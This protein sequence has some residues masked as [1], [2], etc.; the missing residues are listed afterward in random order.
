MKIAVCGKGGSGKSTITSLLAKEFAS[1]GR[2][3]LVIDCDESNYGLH[4]QLGM[5]IPTSLTE[6]MGGKRHV[7][8]GLSNGPQN[9]PMLFEHRWSIDELPKECCSEKDGIKLLTPGKIETANEACACAFAVVMLQFMAILDLKDD[10]IVIMDMEAGIE[11]FGRGTDNTTDAV[12]MVVD[13][14]YES[15]KLSRKVAEM[16]KSIG[17][18]LFYILN[19]TNAENEAVMREAVADYGKILASLP[20]DAEI[21]KAGLMGTE[22]S[23]GNSQAVCMVDALLKN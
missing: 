21:Q 8:S 7:M 20:M 11:H 15:I 19:K 10:E 4:Q 6:Y 2:K 3:V 13:P 23:S 17:K 12:L 18:E 14:S 9:M 16:S 1:R 22:L 5:D